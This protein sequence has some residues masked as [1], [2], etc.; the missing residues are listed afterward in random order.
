L[1]DTVATTTNRDIMTPLAPSPP[2]KMT[3]VRHR[4]QQQPP[5][6][7]PPIIEE[8]QQ[9]ANQQLQLQCI[10]ICWAFTVKNIQEI[11]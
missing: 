8:R 10:L 6:Q 5:S 1:G 4:C 11:R 7:Q 2:T 9:L 3:T